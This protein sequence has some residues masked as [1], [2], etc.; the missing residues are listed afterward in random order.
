MYG[1][2]PSSGKVTLKPT[3]KYDVENLV[4][5]GFYCVYNNEI[6]SCEK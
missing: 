4:V 1:T 6:F 2:R 5:N 3:G